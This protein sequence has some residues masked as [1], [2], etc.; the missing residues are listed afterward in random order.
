[1]DPRAAGQ[2]PALR[3]RH[4]LAIARAV[5]ELRVLAELCLP[6][7]RVGG[8]WVAAKGA[9]PGGEVA[10]A[11]GALG[12]LGGK[13]A[14]V[15]EVD[16]GAGEVVRVVLGAV[17]G[18]R[19]CSNFRTAACCCPCCAARAESADGRRTAVVVLK[20]KSTP[21]LYPRKPGV[22]GKKPLQ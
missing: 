11:A 9:G 22:P 8:H 15:E 14:A 17:T 18:L 13:L 20:A 1:M 3:Q 4:D 7:V 10:A 2:S 6:L 21:D 12:R 19:S 5:A 16:S